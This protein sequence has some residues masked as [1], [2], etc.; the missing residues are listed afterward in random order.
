[1]RLSYRIA[2]F[3]VLLQ[4]LTIGLQGNLLCAAAADA[5]GRKHNNSRY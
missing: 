2:R 3:S 5:H 1:L 4:S